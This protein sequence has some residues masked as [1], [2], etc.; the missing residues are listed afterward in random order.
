MKGDNKQEQSTYEFIR[1]DK[2]KLSHSNIRD[3]NKPNE[4]IQ[5]K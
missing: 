2:I 1:E 5:K 3:R 4:T